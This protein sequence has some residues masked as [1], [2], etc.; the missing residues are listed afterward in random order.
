[1]KISCPLGLLLIASAFTLI[2]DGLNT[3][4]VSTD[5]LRIGRLRYQIYEDEMKRADQGHS[6]YVEYYADHEHKRVVDPIM[7][8]TATNYIAENETGDIIGCLRVNYGRDGK[9][10]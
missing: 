8:T 10:W 9:P 3:V 7:D 6:C 4:K 2:H 1:M 5:L